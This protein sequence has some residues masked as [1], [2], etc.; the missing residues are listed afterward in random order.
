MARG[1][2]PGRARVKRTL[3]VAGP[4]DMGRRL[5]AI[6]ALAL[7]LASAA[8][9]EPWR[10][11]AESG[12]AARERLRAHLPEPVWQHRAIFLP[13]EARPEITPTGDLSPPPA[14]SDATRRHAAAARLEADGRLTGYVAGQPF[15]MDAID[16]A[17][18]DA[19]TRIAWN[20]EHRWRGAGER[21]RFR[22][23]HWDGGER[24]AEPVEGELAR[25]Q[26]AHRVE[27]AHL[28]ARGG[29]L[30]PS[31]MRMR[32]L[33]LEL[34]APYEQRGI[35]IV[36]YRYKTE[37]DRPDDLWA[38]V[39]VRRRV[40]RQ[41]G[42][43][44]SEAML[45]TDLVLEDWEGL[46][47][48]VRAY[49]WRCVGERE[50]MAAVRTRVREWPDVDDPRFGPSGLSLASDRFE[51]RRA[52][53]VRAEPRD[54]EH[55]YGWKT[56]Y[57]D[58]Q[59]L[60]PLYLLAHDRAGALLRVGAFAG[61]WSGDVPERYPG[62]EGVPEPRDAFVVAQAIANVQLGTGVRVEFW[63]PTGA[64]LESKGRLRRLI[65]VVPGGCVARGT[66]IDT[67]DGPRAVESLEVGERVWAW[68]PDGQRRIAAPIEAI[69]HST[70]EKTMQ[71]GQRGLRATP[72]HPIWTGA[73]FE[74]LERVRS[75]TALLASDGHV[76][77]AQRAPE[78]ITGSV[79]VYDLS[80][81]WPHT[82]FAD[83]VLV[84]NKSR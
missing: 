25:V 55:P 18:P 3:I 2:R 65:D 70:T 19:G 8:T 36:R 31:G 50:V 7:G 38:Y 80:V 15:P 34:D 20:F 56:L 26:T 57:L 1:A 29:D 45:G 66:R 12:E 27:P 46:G 73:G 39:P 67:P 37:R 84:H 32:V 14:W 68:D 58:R 28:E 53:V 83:G 10:T 77:A 61:G 33:V 64:P 48:P 71:L 11:D 78:P 30:F 5:R 6:V 13:P 63:T 51:L 17:A 23:S 35:R 9:A 59:T 75:G 4:T 72:D 54:P 42:D 52:V 60:E 81:A 40:A 24:I 22:V 47:S 62:W 74:P 41:T 69:A 44:F 76:R 49:R 21:G 16:C 79:E 43:R 82:Y